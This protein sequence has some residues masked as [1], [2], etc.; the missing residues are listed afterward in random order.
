MKNLSCRTEKSENRN[1]VLVPDFGSKLVPDFG[2]KISLLVPD[3]GSKLVPDFGTKISFLVPDFG[4]KLVPDSGTE[5][6]LLVLNFGS[7]LVPDSGTENLTF[8]TRFGG[9]M[10]TRFWYTKPQFSM[11]CV[12]LSWEGKF[13]SCIGHHSKSA[14]MLEALCGPKL[15]PDFGAQNL[16]FGTRFW[17]KI[18][19]RF[20]YPKPHFWF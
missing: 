9:K 10:R 13:E 20:W 11:T 1:L 3:F 16:A 2:T 7:K 18:G 14:L 12:A 6:S 17:P 19:S 8:G 4:S 5:I 15:I